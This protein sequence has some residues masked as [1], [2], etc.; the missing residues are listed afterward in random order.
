M[1][2]FMLEHRVGSMPPRRPSASWLSDDMACAL[3]AMYPP[4]QTADVLRAA[5]RLSQRAASPHVVVVVMD[6]MLPPNVDPRSV[7]SVVHALY[8]LHDV[9]PRRTP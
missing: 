2:K 4:L 6:R 1:T 9:G 7:Q 3:A 8:A 5:D